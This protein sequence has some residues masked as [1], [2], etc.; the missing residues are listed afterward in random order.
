MH[1]DP[2]KSQSYASLVIHFFLM[3][4]QLLLDEAGILLSQLTVLEMGLQSEKEVMDGEEVQK[5]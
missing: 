5:G 2:K 1:P 3:L 4:L